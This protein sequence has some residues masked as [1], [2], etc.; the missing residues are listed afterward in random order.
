MK[1]FSLY[2]SQNYLAF[3][4]A[5][6]QTFR[7]K[8]KAI[9]GNLQENIKNLPTLNKFF[10]PKLI[11]D[12]SPYRVKFNGNCLRQDSVSFHHK[13]VVNSNIS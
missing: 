3:M 9:H 11:T 2:G 7:N 8:Q 4:P 12:Y 1:Y 5:E 6:I 13:N 10:A